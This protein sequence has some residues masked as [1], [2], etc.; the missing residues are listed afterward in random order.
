VDGNFVFAAIKY[1]MDIRDRLEKLLQGGEV[2]LFVLRSVLQELD[3][4]GDK[5][6]GAKE[7]VSS[8]CEVIDD[9]Q[10]GGATPSERLVAFVG[11]IPSRLAL[12]SCDNPFAHV[13]D[14]V[15]QE[16]G[17]KRKRYMIATQ[18]Q[19]LRRSLAQVP[20]VPLIYLN[21]VTLVL[22][23]PSQSSLQYNRNVSMLSELFPVRVV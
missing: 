10:Y 1:K 21:L 5:A 7:F 17:S 19:E 2:K 15:C 8:Y 16:A 9:S 14:R 23:A 11:K 6:K 4:V 22:E 12:A 3:K 18:D 20:G 13:T